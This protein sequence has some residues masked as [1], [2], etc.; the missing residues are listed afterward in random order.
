MPQS[1]GKKKGEIFKM[2]GNKNYVGTYVIVTKKGKVIEK[3][4][5]KGTAL[6][7]KPELEKQWMQKLEI[8]KVK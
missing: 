2:K 1:E 4:K 7:M 5:L 6:Y 3:F 8:K